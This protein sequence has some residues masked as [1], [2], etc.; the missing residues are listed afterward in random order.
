[1]NVSSKSTL[2]KAQ[3][4]DSDTRELLL[5][6]AGDLMLERGTVHISF[7]DI[8]QKSGVNAALIKYYFG[9]KSGMLLELVR[10]AVGASV[11]QLDG[12]LAMSLPASEKLR[13]H[14]SGVVNTYHR[15]PYI[16]RLLHYIL[17]LEDANYGEIIAEEVVKPLAAAQR[18][19]LEEGWASGQFRKV[20]PMLFYFHVVGA[21]DHLF[22]ARN[23]LKRGFGV[24]EVTEELK[25][26]YSRHLADMIFNGL[27]APASGHS[28]ALPTT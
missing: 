11:A 3:P 23:A 2:T 16:N 22:Y 6:A 5:N 4:E 7:S 26:A 10:R 15:Y 8:A 25:M 1:M 17:S 18:R 28:D 20:D 19:I 21:C 12:L 9:N 24:D 14:I 13:I 27:L